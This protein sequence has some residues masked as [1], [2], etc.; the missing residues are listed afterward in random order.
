MAVFRGVYQA[1]VEFVQLLFAFE[2]AQVFLITLK[3][4]ALFEVVV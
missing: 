1:R 4:Q 3:G 2:N